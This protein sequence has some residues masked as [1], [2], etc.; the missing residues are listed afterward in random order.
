MVFWGCLQPE[1][2]PHGTVRVRINSEPATLNGFLL[3]DANK[4]TILSYLQWSPLS[5]DPLGLDWTPVVAEALPQVDSLIDGRLSVKIRL[6]KEARWDDGRPVTGAD[7]VFSLKLLLCPGVNSQHLKNFYLL[8]EDARVAEKDSQTYEVIFR[9]P[10]FNAPFLA[11][12][13]YLFPEHKTDSTGVMR[14]YSVRDMLERPDSVARDSNIQ[15]LAH[16]FNT[17]YHGRR[18]VFGCGPYRLKSWETDKRIVLERKENWWGD[19]LSNKNNVPVFFTARPQTLVFEIIKDEQSALAALR[20]GQIDLINGISPLAFE[21]V[22]TQQS[23]LQKFTPNQMAYHAL[24]FNLRH[25]VLAEKEIRRALAHLVPTAD[26][27]H[28]VFRNTVY[29]AATFIHP[30]RTEWLN[31]TLRPYPFNVQYASEVL[32]KN[33]WHD[34]DKDGIPDKLLQGRRQKL[35]F[36]ILTNTGNPARQN[37]AEMISASAAQAGIKL[38]IRLMELPQM[39]EKMRSHD[40]DMFLGGM[41]SSVVESDP[42]QIWHSTAYSMGSNFTGFS[43][44]EADALIERYRVTLDR[45]QRMEQLKKLQALVYEEIP[46]VFIV[47]EKDRMV[48]SARLRGLTVS[49]QRPGYWLGTVDLERREAE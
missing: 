23:P 2:R 36:T 1:S 16:W 30:T 37:M 44:P 15:K 6:R 40:F 28:V 13:L 42:F 38:D 27:V 5:I 10:Y 46:V 22:D 11:G 49:D 7:A 32:R 31:D 47:A 20:S 8:M 34:S 29:P 17:E 33:G 21:Q 14:R 41:V 12:D 48:A 26:I 43:R 24:Y 3:G 19:A 25:P 9:K 45:R 39:I 35:R 4:T 18:Y